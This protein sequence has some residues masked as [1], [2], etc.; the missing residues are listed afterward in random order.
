MPM[1]NTR[2]RP[3]AHALHD[4]GHGWMGTLLQEGV[5]ENGGMDGGEEEEEQEA[6]DDDNDEDDEDMIVV[7]HD[8][9]NLRQGA[10]GHASIADVLTV[11]LMKLWRDHVKPSPPRMW[12]HSNRWHSSVLC[13]RIRRS[14][15]DQTLRPHPPLPKGKE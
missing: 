6:D 3:I 12:Q 13:S 5:S 1:N 15:S 7:H 4:R 8:K 9:S 10:E 14:D 2:F 11:L